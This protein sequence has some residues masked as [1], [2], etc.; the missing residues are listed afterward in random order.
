MRSDRQQCNEPSNADAS[1]AVW[2]RLPA[3]AAAAAAG[4][5]AGGPRP[6]AVLR[7]GVADRAEGVRID[8]AA[9]TAG[10]TEAAPCGDEVELVIEPSAMERFWLGGLHEPAALIHGQLR[11][12]GRVDRVLDV[13]PALAP[14]SHRLAAAGHSEARPSRFDVLMPARPPLRDLA[15]SGLPCELEF[16]PLHQTA[17]AAYVLSTLH[18]TCRGLEAT[19]AVCACKADELPVERITGLVETLAGVAAIAWSGGRFESVEDST[20]GVAEAIRLAASPPGARRAEIA[21]LC[22]RFASGE[23]DVASTARLVGR[24]C[25]MAAAAMDGIATRATTPAPAAPVTS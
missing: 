8:F 14:I 9:G 23:R 10:R 22:A 1:S 13:L 5:A 15:A 18:S 4:A 24:L 3:A 21:A 16:E 6:Y 25:D 2:E 17:L 20:P 19:Y 12:R 7:V 11:V